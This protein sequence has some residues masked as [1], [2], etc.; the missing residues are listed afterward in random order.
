MSAIAPGDRGPTIGLSSDVKSTFHFG[1]ERIYPAQTVRSR[2]NPQPIRF[3]ATRPAIVA[4]RCAGLAEL[5]DAT[6]SK[7][8]VRKDVWVRVPHSALTFGCP[9]LAESARGGRSSFIKGGRPPPP[10][11]G[12]GGR[13]GFYCGGPPPRPRSAGLR[14]RTPHVRGCVGIGTVRCDLALVGRS[15]EC[16]PGRR[17]AWLRPTP[18][19]VVV[20]SENGALLPSDRRGTH[21]AQAR[22]RLDGLRLPNST[23]VGRL[24]GRASKLGSGPRRTGA[25]G[26]SSCAAPAAPGSGRM[27]TS[28]VAASTPWTTT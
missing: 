1:I 5:A 15:W 25:G 9:L 17:S 13:L 16:G 4:I 28:P 11:P 3:H 24:L 7:T 27:P 14:P 18:A 12:G 20:L 8:V 6:V 10:P 23:D 19:C 22:P 26:R 21:E 2:R